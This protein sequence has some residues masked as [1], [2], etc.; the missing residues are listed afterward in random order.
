MPVMDG[1]T[2]TAELR[3]AGY[4]YPIVALTAHAMASD[5]ERCLESGCDD[6]AT[7]PIDR[8][9]LLNLIERYMNHA[10]DQTVSAP[11]PPS[12]TQVEGPF[13]SEQLS[14]STT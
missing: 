5:R 6:Y 7:K 8:V 9:A 10:A 14:D 11:L 12:V 3:S 4:A 13:Q 1:Y 2:A